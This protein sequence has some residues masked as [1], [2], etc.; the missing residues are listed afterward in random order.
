LQFSAEDDFFIDFALEAA[1]ELTV[2]SPNMFVFL[3]RFWPRYFDKL[4][5]A[6]LPTPYLTIGKGEENEGDLVAIFVSF[7]K[8]QEE[9]LSEKAA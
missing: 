1:D 6:A 5:N 9:L 2:S 7:Q 4:R 8:A 3:Q